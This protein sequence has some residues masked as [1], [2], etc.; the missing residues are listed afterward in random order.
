MNARF[1]LVLCVLS[2]LIR[3]V[4][5]NAQ[6]AANGNVLSAALGTQTDPAAVSDGAGGA[7]VVW[8]D[9]R[10]GDWDIFAHRVNAWGVLQW[11]VPQNGTPVRTGLNDHTDPQIISDGLGGAIIVWVNEGNNGNTDIYAQRLDASGNFQWGIS[12]VALTSA[13]QDQHSPAVVSDGAG[14]AIVVWQDLRDGSNMTADIYARRINSGG[15]AQWTSDG[16]AISTALNR[17]ELPT[18]VEDGSGGAIIAW[19]DNRTDGITT[20]VYAQRVNSAGAAQWTAN[21]VALVTASGSQNA[22]TMTTD[23]AGGAIA[24]WTDGRWRFQTFTRSV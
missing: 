13:Q 2:F 15:A 9:N 8:A 23:G 5:S 18:L 6:W 21:G 22:V 7:F 10:S 19:S 20:D 4:D 12:G 16:V 3:P 17:Q 14:G 24:A 1:I 11:P